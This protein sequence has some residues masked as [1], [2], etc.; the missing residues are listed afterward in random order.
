MF[1]FHAEATTLKRS[2][3]PLPRLEGSTH[4]AVMMEGRRVRWPKFEIRNAL[5]EGKKEKK[6]PRM[7]FERLVNPYASL[8]VRCIGSP[9]RATL[10]L[11]C[12][13]SIIFIEPT[14]CSTVI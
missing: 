3:V 4:H 11:A 1:S 5:Y 12:S 14:H 2:A 6:A 7:Y 10:I 9:I 8:K 13:L